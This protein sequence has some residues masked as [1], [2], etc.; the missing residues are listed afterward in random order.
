MPLYIDRRKSG[1]YR[2]RGTHHGVTI[3]RSAKT[4][5][6]SEAEAIRERWER[7]I[8][9]QQVHGKAA[10]YSFSEAVIDYFRAGGERRY[11][12]EV[13]Q[14]LG[15]H[16]VADLRQ[17]DLDRAALDAYPTAKPSTINRQ[18]YTPF[19]AVMT[20]AAHNDRCQMRTWRRPKQ[21]EGRMDWRTPS[22]MESIL[23]ALAPR[24]RGLAEFMLGGFPRVSEALAMLARDVSPGCRR[25]TFWET[26][27]GYS[28][29]VDLPLRAQ[30][31]IRQALHGINDPD[32]ALWRT[33][34][35]GLPWHAYDAFNLA[36]KRA[37][38][39]AGARPLSSHTLRH[40]GATWRYS[41]ERD[42]PRLM[43]AGGWRSLAMVQRYVHAGTDDLA[44]AVKAAGWAIG[45]QTEWKEKRDA[46]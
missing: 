38:R 6:R 13:L 18:F 27:G 40:T 16:D 9:A 11:M 43:A 20:L 44:D 12:M 14:A 39:D 25:A 34:R 22:E 31:A 45:G 30:E 33:D 10:P 7:E 5:S 3:D 2:I 17:S 19:I 1:I 29:H 23:A 36:L 46:Q 24:A 41:T 37:C 28:R 4:R 21:P 42:L 35:D 8:F 32:S 26:K 15:S